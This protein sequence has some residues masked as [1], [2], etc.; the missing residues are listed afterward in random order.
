VDGEFDIGA[1]VNIKI[2][3]QT[4]IARGLVS[5][6]SHDIR[7]IQGHRTDAIA[8]ILGAANYEEV[9]HRDNM[10]LLNVK[11]RMSNDKSTEVAQ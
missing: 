4:L 6:S 5:Y 7:L 9:I 10:V 11:G 3:D 8:G 1:A 2:A